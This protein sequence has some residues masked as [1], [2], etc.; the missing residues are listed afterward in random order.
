[1]ERT[2]AERGAAASDTVA[3]ALTIFSRGAPADP[4]KV[5][6]VL[7]A[8]LRAEAFHLGFIVVDHGIGFFDGRFP[9]LFFSRFMRGIAFS[10]WHIQALH[11]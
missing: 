2:V 4:M 9:G 5:H 3:A 6:D 8:A 10:G 7:L 1:M 11:S